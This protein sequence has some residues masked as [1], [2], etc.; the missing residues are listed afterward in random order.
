MAVG[1]QFALF[2]TVCA[3]AVFS[4]AVIMLTMDKMVR[5]SQPHLFLLLLIAMSFV[6]ATI[7]HPDDTGRATFLWTG[8]AAVCMCIVAGRWKESRQHIGYLCTLAVAMF[9]VYTLV[10]NGEHDEN[11]TESP[12]QLTRC[13]REVVGMT[14]FSV[15]LNLSVRFITRRRQRRVVDQEN[16]TSYERMFRDKNLGKVS[17]MN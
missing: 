17:Q 8:G 6:G 3:I 4:Y 11:G 7:A 1:D 16:G 5:R 12:P 10:T 14:L 2:F 9:G 13:E 15:V